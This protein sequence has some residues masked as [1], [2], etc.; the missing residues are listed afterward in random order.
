MELKNAFEKACNAYLY[1]F[2]QRYESDYD[3]AETSWVAGKVGTITCI[4]DL[5]I[6]MEDIRLCIDENISWDD[7]IS[8]YD[9]CLRVSMLDSYLKEPRTI[10]LPNLES[11]IKGCPRKSEEEL[12]S[13]EKSKDRIEELKREF[14]KQIK[15]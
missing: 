2:C 8:H 13:L 9:Y 11:W 6:N 10:A 14:E 3:D 1:E 5:Y 15:E 7:F 4:G 12:V